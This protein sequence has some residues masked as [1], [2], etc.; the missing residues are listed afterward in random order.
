MLAPKRP[1]PQRWISFIGSVLLLASV[2]AACSL[3]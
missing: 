2:A 3:R 1:V